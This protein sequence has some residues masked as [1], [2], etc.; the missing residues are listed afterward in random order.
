VFVEPA[1]AL[2]ANGMS[3]AARSSAIADATGVAR[4][5]KSSSEGTIRRVS[6]GKPRRSTA[7]SIEKWVWSEA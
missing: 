4:R 2:M 6:A 1:T 7:R 3:P 5:R